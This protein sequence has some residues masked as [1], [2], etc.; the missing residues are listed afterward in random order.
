M[1]YNEENHKI[2]FVRER[3]PNS[4]NFL[5]IDEKENAIDS[6]V[7]ATKFLESVNSDV[8]HWKWIV[9]A[10][11]NALYGFMICALEKGNPD[12]VCK[13]DKKQ[14]KYTR[15]L[16]GFQ[17]AL[18]RVQSRDHIIGYVE[19]KPIQLTNE[20]T[21]SIKVLTE[22][23]RNNFEHFVPTGWSIE[24]SGMSTIVRS[25]ADTIND[26]VFKTGTV[27]WEEHQLVEI[28]NAL[29]KLKQYHN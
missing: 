28:K 20:Q 21:R 19:T 14:K 18:E 16:I 4:L 15:W 8:Y 12:N 11:H 2:D 10:L 5:C 22:L 27:F 3:K 13:Y 6:L 29:E 24:I 26:L 1:R 7:M 9:I 23:L 17:T 25:I